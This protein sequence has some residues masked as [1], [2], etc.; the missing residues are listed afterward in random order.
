MAALSWT[1][2]RPRGW[3][4]IVLCLLMGSGSDPE[5]LRARALSAA[6]HTLT[7]HPP[8]KT[9]S[10]P[11]DLSRAACKPSLLKQTTPRAQRDQQVPP[12]LRNQRLLYSWSWCSLFSWLEHQCYL[13]K[14]AQNAHEP[15]CTTLLLV[16]GC[17]STRNT[18]QRAGASRGS[19]SN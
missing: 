4:A 9:S 3:D 2:F 17:L 15:T 18:A 14:P 6:T 5:L 7:P 12:S 19:G 16:L 1:P 11:P 8:W 10:F 13:P